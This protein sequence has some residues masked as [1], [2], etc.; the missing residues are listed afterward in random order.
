MLLCG[1]LVGALVLGFG[2]LLM[3]A[4]QPRD[5]GMRIRSN[6]GGREVVTDLEPIPRK[7]VDPL[8]AWR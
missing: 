3:Q 6:Y 8:I 5:S 2:M 4:I 1:V 7:R